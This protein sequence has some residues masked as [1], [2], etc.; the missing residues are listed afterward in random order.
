MIWLLM[1]R[2]CETHLCKNW[3]VHFF[4]LYR[5][6]SRRLKINVKPL[7]STNLKTCSNGAIIWLINKTLN[8]LHPMFTD[9]LNFSNNLRIQF[10]YKHLSLKMLVAKF[11]FFHWTNMVWAGVR[12]GQVIFHFCD[13]RNDEGLIC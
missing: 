2:V 12:T 13:V 1:L 4:I 9:F 6:L 10:V 11:I 5:G 7:F 3:V 8:L